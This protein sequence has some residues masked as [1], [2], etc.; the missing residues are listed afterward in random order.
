MATVLNLHEQGAFVAVVDVQEVP[1]DISKKLSAKLRFWQ[2][3]LTVTEEVA[4]AVEGAAAWARETHAPLGG[5]I[6][7]AG[8]GAAAKVRD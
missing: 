8:I 3:D 2:T 4:R 7:C 5:V 1:S 6:N